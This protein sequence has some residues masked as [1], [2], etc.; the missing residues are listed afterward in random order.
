MRSLAVRPQ[1]TRSVRLVDEAPAHR[2]QSVLD[3]VEHPG[4]RECMN[5]PIGQRQIDGAAGWVRP[6]AGIGPAVVERHARTAP[7]EEY[8]EQRAGRSRAG[9]GDRCAR[10]IHEAAARARTS[11]A[12]ATSPNE[13]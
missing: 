5:A 2:N 10:E 7:L 4:E 12:R 11:T 9:K 8:R 1:L 6:P 3:L 13:L